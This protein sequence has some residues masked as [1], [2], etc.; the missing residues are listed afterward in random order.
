MS[1]SCLAVAPCG[2][3]N[4]ACCCMCSALNGTVKR[5]PHLQHTHNKKAVAQECTLR[6]ACYLKQK[7]GKAPV[8][9]RTLGIERQRRELA[10]SVALESPPLRAAYEAFPPNVSDFRSKFA[11]GYCERA[12]RRFWPPGPKSKAKIDQRTSTRESK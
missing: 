12:R 5:Q 8:Q 1:A 10:L 9:N 6:E 4:K 3:Q 7:Q 2:R 11:L